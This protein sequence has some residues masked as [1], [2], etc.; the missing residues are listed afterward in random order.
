MRPFI[1]SRASTD[2][3]TGSLIDRLR[4]WSMVGFHLDIQS[5][6]LH[7]AGP[8]HAEANVQFTDCALSLGWIIRLWQA[9]GTAGYHWQV[10]CSLDICDLINAASLVGGKINKRPTKYLLVECMRCVFSR[11]REKNENTFLPFSGC[12]RGRRFSFTSR[13]RLIV[14]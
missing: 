8:R 13:F 6:V 9:E 2:I 3:L 5:N 11:D 1:S 12:W 10:N 4:D 7:N 14:T